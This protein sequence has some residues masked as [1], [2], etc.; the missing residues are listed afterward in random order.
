MVKWIREWTADPEV[1]VQVQV[2]M[3]KEEILEYRWED[4]GGVGKKE[5]GV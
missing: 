1:G 4:E 3:S 2:Q 5:G